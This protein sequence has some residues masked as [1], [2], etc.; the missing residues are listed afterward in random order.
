[1]DIT[2]ATFGINEFNKNLN[3]LEEK[4]L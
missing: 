2:I 1:L 3:F 4:R